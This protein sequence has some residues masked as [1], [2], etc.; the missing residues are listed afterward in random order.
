MSELVPSESLEA[1]I[2]RSC[3]AIYLATDPDTAMHHWARLRQLKALK[4]DAENRLF[5]LETAH[6]ALISQRP[7]SNVAPLV[8]TASTHGQLR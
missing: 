4:A 5:L 3:E 6:R 1:Q 7:Q 8:S 2:A